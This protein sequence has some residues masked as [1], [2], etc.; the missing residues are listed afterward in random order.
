MLY[1]GLIAISI[2]FNYPQIFKIVDLNRIREF[3]DCQIFR[4]FYLY[5]NPVTALTNSFALCEGASRLR[6]AQ[7]KY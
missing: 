2:T 4:F 5:I 3:H 1:Y 6:I 7:L